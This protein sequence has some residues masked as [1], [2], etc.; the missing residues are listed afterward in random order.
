[1]VLK[2]PK[3]LFFLRDIE[4]SKSKWY[5]HVKR[6]ENIRLAKIYPEWS[7]YG[8]RSVGKPRKRWFDRIQEALEKRGFRL[9][10]MEERR[11]F[12]DRSTWRDVV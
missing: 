10:D 12:G 11:T 8:K 9:V 4:K 3:L 5:G 7:S 2:A 6:K 1:M